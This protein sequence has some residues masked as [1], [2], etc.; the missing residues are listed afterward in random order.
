MDAAAWF[1]IE[2]HL[3]MAA[4]PPITRV[5]SGGG[6]NYDK[7][8]AEFNDHNQKVIAMVETI[9]A[10]ELIRKRITT[11]SVPMKLSRYY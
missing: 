4:E 3:A 6:V 10:C 7:R 8:T 11:N 1:G 2:K 9:E 5:P